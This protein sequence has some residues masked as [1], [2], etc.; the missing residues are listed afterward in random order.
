MLQQEKFYFQHWNSQMLRGQ[1]SL[2]IHVAGRLSAKEQNSAL[3]EAVR[4]AD[5]PKENF[6][7]TTI[8]N[9]DDAIP[10]SPI[11]VERSLKQ[12]KKQAI[13]EHFI[14]DGGS[15]AQHAWQLTRRGSAIVVLDSAGIIRFAKDGALTAE[16][17]KQ[18]ITQLHQLTDRATAKQAPLP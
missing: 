10:G 8:V 14:I 3:I 7:T 2:L 12:S 1:V 18:V 11:F 16:E 13:R 17:V 9:T 15:V 5:F 4:Q 6:R